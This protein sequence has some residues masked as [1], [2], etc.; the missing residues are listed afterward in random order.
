MTDTAPIKK[1]TIIYASAR[2]ESLNRKLAEIVR[3]KLLAQN[4]QVEMP[5]Y[6]TLDM[7]IF[8]DDAR[9]AGNIP[10]MAEKLRDILQD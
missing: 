5:D 7:P 4:I 3:Q 10:L 6:T 9:Q 8:N 1:A 2:K